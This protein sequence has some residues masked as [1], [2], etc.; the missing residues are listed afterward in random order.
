MFDMLTIIICSM[1]AGAN[2]ACPIKDHEAGVYKP[3]WLFNGGIGMF[4][5]CVA[6]LIAFS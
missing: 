4:C 1:F 6:L 5:L 2:F 3:Q